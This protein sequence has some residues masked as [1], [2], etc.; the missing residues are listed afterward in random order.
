MTRDEHMKWCKE[1]AIQ[2][3]DFYLKPDG[4]KAAVRNG[5]TSMMSDM[6]KHP[7]TNSSSMQ[8][9]CLHQML[10]GMSSRQAFVNFINGFN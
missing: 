1:R 2:E 8:S 7:E 3:F 9:L 6:S 5:L 10:I 4:L